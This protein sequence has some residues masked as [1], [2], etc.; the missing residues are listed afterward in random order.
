LIKPTWEEGDT[1]GSLCAA[2]GNQ[3][4]LPAES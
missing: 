3:S 4:A 1:M 2:S